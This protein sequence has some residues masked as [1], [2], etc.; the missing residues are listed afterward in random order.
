MKKV[1]VGEEEVEFLEEGDINSLFDQ[2][3]DVAGRRGVSEKL[4]NKA[5]K[6]IIKQTKKA[7]KSID[8]GKPNADKLR[9]LRDST[10]RLE[11]IVKDPSSYT[12]EVMQ[13]ILKSV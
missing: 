3:L 7:Q 2:I 13:E 10:R 1:K 9:R 6:S 4:I 8:K 5:K 11:D 12:R